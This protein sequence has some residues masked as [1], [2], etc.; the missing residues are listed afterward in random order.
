MLNAQQTEAFKSGEWLKYRMSYSN[1]FNAGYAELSL[2][3]TKK[4]GVELFHAKG[5]GKTTGVIGWFF[6]VR[7]K[8]ES[9]FTRSENSPVHFV[10]RVDEG[11]HIISRDIY[12][13]SEAN[14]A[15]IKNH[16]KKTEKTMSVSDVQ[17][18]ISAVYKLRNENLCSMKVGED[19]AMKL[20]FDYESFDFK[21]RYLGKE[22]LRTK[23]GKVNCLK[24]RPI[25][26]AG[27]VF[28]EEES[29]TIWISDDDNKIP[30]KVK[31]SLA[32]GS[33]RADLD[34][35]KGLANP[36]NIIYKN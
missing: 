10:R 28:K 26:Q 5:T 7:D 3:K 2:K 20:F 1:F 33:L 31:A 18:M 13:D 24:F 36:F 15:Y 35:F 21:M 29:V 19:I 9:F 30:L 14:T 34:A 8:Y 6:K 25:V 4:K 27:R 17:D 23:F 11:G 16:K 22:V 12:F 32:V